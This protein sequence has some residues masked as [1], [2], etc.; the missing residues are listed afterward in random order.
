ML[1][2][3]TASYCTE[4][5]GTPLPRSYNQAWQGYTAHYYRGPNATLIGLRD[6]YGLTNRDALQSNQCLPEKISVT[7]SFNLADLPPIATWH[8]WWR[9]DTAA[10]RPELDPTLTAAIDRLMQTKRRPVRPLI[11]TPQASAGRLSQA[12]ATQSPSAPCLSALPN[13]QEQT[14]TPIT[15]TPV[16]AWFA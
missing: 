10:R 13:A 16:R 12:M 1:G 6:F 14:P 4:N 11:D 7:Q 9:F 2:L 5:E 8:N 15:L 3:R